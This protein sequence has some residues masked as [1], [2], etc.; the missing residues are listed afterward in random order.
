MQSVALSGVHTDFTFLVDVDLVPHVEFRRRL[1]HT[2]STGALQQK[3]VRQAHCQQQDG[4][5]VVQTQVS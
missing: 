4:V 3:Q 5:G 1:I 2:L